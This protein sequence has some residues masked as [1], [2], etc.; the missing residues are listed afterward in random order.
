[1][2]NIQPKMNKIKV[3]GVEVW[4]VVARKN[5]GQ[6]QVERKKNK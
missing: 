1:M 5:A 6:I 2:H 3:N 4:T